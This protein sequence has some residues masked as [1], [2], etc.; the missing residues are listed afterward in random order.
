LEKYLATYHPE[1]YDAIVRDFD[2]HQ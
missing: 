2:L 1:E